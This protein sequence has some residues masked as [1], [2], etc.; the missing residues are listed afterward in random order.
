MDTTQTIAEMKAESKKNDIEPVEVYAGTIWEA[1]LVKSLLENAEI[2]TFLND[3]NT[4]TLAP[5]YTAGGG[6][7]SVKVIVSSLDFDKA[8]TVIEEFE[9]N[10]GNA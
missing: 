5:W 8:K 6:A 1:E 9:Q 10:M 2:E 4:G 3:E 7:G